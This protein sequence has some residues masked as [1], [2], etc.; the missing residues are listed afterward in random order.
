M[1]SCREVASVSIPAVLAA[2]T[3]PAGIRIKEHFPP[4]KDLEQNQSSRAPL[5]SCKVAA[6]RG[7][8]GAKVAVSGYCNSGFAVAAHLRILPPGAPGIF[9]GRA[10]TG[11]A[12]PDSV[13]QCLPGAK[14]IE[15]A[16]SVAFLCL[17]A[18]R[19]PKLRAGRKPV[20]SPAPRFLKREF[21]HPLFATSQGHTVRSHSVAD[22]T[23]SALVRRRKLA[24]QGLHWRKAVF[25]L[26]KTP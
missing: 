11:A 6:P 18:P 26:R 22:H 20:P 19:T 10:R 9:M 24:C 23:D 14:W 12:L 3:P 2:S 15:P 16:Q 21:V 5:Q 7:R 17:R 13:P 4:V 8:V 25:I 1:N